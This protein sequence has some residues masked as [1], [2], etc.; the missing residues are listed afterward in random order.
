MLTV[1]EAT[2]ADNAALLSLVQTGTG[3]AIDR[4]PDFFAR[5]RLYEGTKTYVAEKDGN[6]VGAVSRVLKKMHVNGGEY[7]ASYLF[8]IDYHKPVY[9]EALLERCRQEDDAAGA[10]F[11]YLQLLTGNPRFSS[12]FTPWDFAEA[13]RTWLTVLK[14]APADERL[15]SGARAA[16]PDDYP[17]IADLMNYCYRDYDYYTPVTAAELAKLV[18]L[19]GYAAANLYVT[20]ANGTINACLGFLDYRHIY[21]FFNY[22]RGARPGRASTPLYYHLPWLPQPDAPWNGI[23]PFPLAYRNSVE[24]LLPLWQL[25]IRFTAER[26]LMGLCRFD[27]N[28]PLRALTQHEAAALTSSPMPLLIRQYDGAPPPQGRLVYVDQR[29]L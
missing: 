22:S 8:D 14:P 9:D 23:V 24:E 5:L 13:A 26:Q 12:R 1:R 4:G 3:G 10:A 16:T 7:L 6:I 21:L 25:Y 29:D 15:L 17:A 2:A 19:P 18:V 11:S 28:D 27:Q 20:P